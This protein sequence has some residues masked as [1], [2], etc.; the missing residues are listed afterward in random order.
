M[1]YISHE[2]YKDLMFRFQ[3]NTSKGMLKEAVEE[4]NA[5]TAALAKTKKG[6]KAKVGGEEITDTSNYDDPSVA[7]GY[8]DR[9]PG[10][11]K[12]DNIFK[13]KREIEESHEGNT[14]WIEALVDIL[15]AKGIDIPDGFK[16]EDYDGM[17]PQQ[18]ADKIESELMNDS[19]DDYPWDAQD[20]SDDSY[21]PDYGDPGADFNDGEFWEGAKKVEEDSFDDLVQGDRDYDRADAMRGNLEGIARSLKDNYGMSKEEVHDYLVI[22][23]DVDDMTAEAIVDDVFGPERSEE[24]PGFKGTWDK[25]DNLSIREEEVGEGLHM[26]PL[27]ATGP[28]VDVNEE[29]EGE[30]TLDSTS[31]VEVAKFVIEKHP[32]LALK[33][34]KDREKHA[35]SHAYEA[36]LNSGM[37][38]AKV[39]AQNLVWGYSN[40]DWPMDYMMAIESMLKGSKK[41]GLNPA[42]MQAT[43]QALKE[44]TVANPP[45][46]FDV[47]SPDERKQLKEYIESVKTIKKEIAKLAAKAGKKVKTEGGD[48]TGLTMTP[49]VTSEGASHEE[50]E[51]IESRIPEKL[52]TAAERVIEELRKA[53]LNDGEIKMFLDHEI[54]EKAKEAAMDQY[55]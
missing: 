48:T 46:G 33:M 54:E 32:E 3:A 28:T 31:P 15:S 11:E 26:P 29:V 35:L 38:K 10:S 7:E 18:A 39:L 21:P 24:M 50:I 17:T 16:S 19:N 43:G 52:Y 47:L 13:E 37:P 34:G 8:A 45:Y 14:R 27:Q 25:L 1:S 49:S 53:G 36:I 55:E 12:L 22:K 42:P 9:Y 4:G 5:F 6:G 44:N 23:R 40:E 51:K 2:D 30:M 20:N 41:E